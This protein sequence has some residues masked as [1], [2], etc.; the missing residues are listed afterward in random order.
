MELLLSFRVLRVRQIRVRQSI[1][2]QGFDIT[3]ESFGE[4]HLH[5]AENSLTLF[6]PQHRKN[7]DA[8]YCHFLPNKLVNT[9]CLTERRASEI[10]GKIL[11][12]SG[13]ELCDILD[14]EGIGEILD[15]ERASDS[16]SE[17]EAEQL[18]NSPAVNEGSSSRADTELRPFLETLPK[19][20]GSSSPSSHSRGRPSGSLH[21][22]PTHG[23]R[24]SSLR[25]NQRETSASSNTDS[26]VA[27]NRPTTNPTKDAIGSGRNQMNR[28]GF[29]S[30]QGLTNGN[31]GAT[32]NQPLEAFP[33]RSPS[34]CLSE[35]LGSP[36]LPLMGATVSPR[37]KSRALR[38]GG[39]SPRHSLD[40]AS[41]AVNNSINVTTQEEEEN[42]ACKSQG[43]PSSEEIGRTFPDLSQRMRR[44]AKSAV[45]YQLPDTNLVMAVNPSNP[46]A[47]AHH[48]TR[49]VLSH[50]CL[51][52][53]RLQLKETRNK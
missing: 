21:L 50:A 2:S 42:D 41:P 48:P 38:E 5:H 6:I 28:I 43:K 44:L 40:S 11:R 9:L 30:P 13:K 53:V 22:N 7:M 39:E 47:N 31:Q 20:P 10:I 25:D 14:E 15:S 19:L 4:M 51:K 8:I 36:E 12:I 17:V 34:F 3:K 37:R 29:S 26:S 46:F 23:S 49:S 24:A 52:D 33:Q 1:D 16:L 27:A 45:S 18:S 32:L 35:G